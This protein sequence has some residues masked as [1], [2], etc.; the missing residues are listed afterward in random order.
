MT[1][2]ELTAFTA[3]DLA[4]DLVADPIVTEIITTK[5]A[6]T[7]VVKAVFEIMASRLASGEQGRIHGFGN[8]TPT[9]RAPRLAHDPRNPK[10]KIEV[11]AKV[12]IA[13]KMAKALKDSLPSSL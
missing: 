7:E 2:S 12:V 8:F 13:F 5:K 10:H 9:E 1:P 4:D 3:K 6:A 11:P